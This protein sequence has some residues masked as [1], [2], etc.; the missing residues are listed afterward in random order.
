[1]KTLNIEI[2]VVDELT[3]RLV[4]QGDINIYNANDLRHEFDRHMFAGVRNFVL[5]FGKMT[6]IDSAGIGVLF[7][8]LNRVKNLP[9]KVIIIQAQPNV[10]KLFEITRVTKFFHILDT[11][12][13]ALAALRA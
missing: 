2:K 4:L 12:S 11:E 13:S 10:L 9:G 3:V 5:D 1:M 6:M 8:M 7:T